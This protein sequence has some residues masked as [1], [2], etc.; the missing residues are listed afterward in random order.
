MVDDAEKAKK[1]KSESPISDV[2]REENVCK[3]KKSVMTSPMVAQT[4]SAQTEQG[5]SAGVTEGASILVCLITRLPY[6]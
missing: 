1:R 6:H 2:V 5:E 3:E 4:A